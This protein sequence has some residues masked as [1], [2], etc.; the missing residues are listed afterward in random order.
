MLSE[1]FCVV[2]N[3]FEIFQGTSSHKMFRS[4]AKRYK[5]RGSKC[6]QTQPINPRSSHVPALL[7]LPVLRYSISPISVYAGCISINKTQ[8]SQARRAGRV[9]RVSQSTPYVQD[10]C[11]LSR[12]F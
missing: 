1:A 5:H 8:P 3:R 11:R 9:G 4:D 12:D 2:V 10:L 7:M 6:Q